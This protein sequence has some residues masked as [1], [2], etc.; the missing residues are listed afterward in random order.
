ME[1]ELF[2]LQK[3]IMDLEQKLNKGSVETSTN[4]LLPPR[5]NQHKDDKTQKV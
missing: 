5:L 2:N 3:K 4:N 1:S